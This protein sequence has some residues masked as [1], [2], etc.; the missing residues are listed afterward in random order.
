MAA[1]PHT[2]FPSSL[3]VLDAGDPL[4]SPDTGNWG[5]RI[6]RTLSFGWHQFWSMN[7]LGI[8]AITTVPRA[9]LQALFFT[10]LGRYI[11]GPAHAHFVL[12]GAPAIT[13]P[14]LCTIGIAD[15]VMVEKWSGTFWRVR[16]GRLP[17]FVMLALRSW[18]YVAVGFAV[19]VVA[20][21]LAGLTV[22][23]ADLRKCIV[24][25]LVV[26][27]F[28]AVS[29]SAAGF[30]GATLAVGK[31]A[32]VV[33]GNLLAY[34]IILTSGAFLPSDRLGAL[35][36]LS[37]LLPSSHAM[38]AAPAA[39]EGRAWLPQ[40]LLEA[41]VGCGWLAVAGLVITVQLRRARRHGHDDFA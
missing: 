38:T 36:P 21:L 22:G 24:P 2:C 33:V 35:K 4:N 11:G 20:A 25:L 40:V 28:M 1:P 23:L 32:D 10:L 18:P 37:W 9:V 14:L 17:P 31:R 7:P 19:S 13:M 12:I 27:A 41:A 34:L 3:T 15:V 5:W 8:L 6:T 26:Y 16:L 29:T 30:A 39:V